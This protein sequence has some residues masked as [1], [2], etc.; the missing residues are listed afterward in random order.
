VHYHGFA[1]FAAAVSGSLYLDR[2]FALAPGGDQPRRR[3][4]RAP[5][6]GFDFFYPEFSIAFIEQNE[7]MPHDIAFD[8]CAETVFS[9]RQNRCG[10]AGSGFNDT[11][12]KQKTDYRYDRRRI[13][14]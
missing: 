2:N 4:R 3:G 12:K 10:G 7:I 6:A 5:S 13:F 1:N 11:R 9:F 8:S 14:H